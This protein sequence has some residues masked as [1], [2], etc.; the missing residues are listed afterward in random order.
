MIE[1]KIA[2]S[3]MLVLLAV[4]FAGMVG[5][6]VADTKLNDFMLYKVLPA[7]GFVIVACM[8]EAI[9]RYL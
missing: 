8:I 1:L 6:Y 7:G 2:L 5:L 3:T 9:F 4:S